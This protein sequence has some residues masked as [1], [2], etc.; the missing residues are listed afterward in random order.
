MKIK[1]EK[2]IKREI[3]KRWCPSLPRV[4]VRLLSTGR[5]TML[6]LVLCHPH[7]GDD[8]KQCVLVPG[9]KYPK[10]GIK[11]IYGKTSVLVCAPIQMIPLQFGALIARNKYLSEPHCCCSS[12]LCLWRNW[13]RA[14]AFFFA[15]PSRLLQLY[16]PSISW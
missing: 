6:V 8:C 4:T 10:T 2:E 9:N 13:K 1:M 12:F 3:K 16:P 11:E 7:E 15:S 5:R 14:P